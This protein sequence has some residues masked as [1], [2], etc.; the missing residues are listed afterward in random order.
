MP[1]VPKLLTL[2][3]PVGRQELA[4]IEQ[5]GMRSF[6][7]RLEGQPIFYPVLNEQYASEIAERWNTRDAHSGYAGFVT[8]FSVLAAYAAHYEVQTVGAARHQEL[9]VPA[10]QLEAFNAQIV[11]LIVV[12]AS[13]E[14]PT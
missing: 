1:D 13:F 14:R 12:I 4:L 7:P 5:S 11:G 10:D 8:R 3:R 9:W 2:Y 6:P